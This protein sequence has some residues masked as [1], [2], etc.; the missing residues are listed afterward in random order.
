MFELC[1]RHYGPIERKAIKRK[2]KEEIKKM[3]RNIVESKRKE[4][5]K[6][7]D[8]RENIWNNKS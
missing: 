5:L 7:K 6:M 4:F 2:G 8:T 3:K 1:L